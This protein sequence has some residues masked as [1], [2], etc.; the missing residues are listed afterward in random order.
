[1]CYVDTKE[2][3]SS[4]GI[5]KIQNIHKF[6]IMTRLSNGF[7]VYIPWL[8]G[9][10]LALCHQSETSCKKGEINSGVNTIAK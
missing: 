5:L 8:R 4:K 2:S 6:I 3:Y 10:S 7:N 1:M 9:P